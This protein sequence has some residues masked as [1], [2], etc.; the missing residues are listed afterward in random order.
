MIISEHREVLE[1][2]G[3]DLQASPRLRRWI[4]ECASRARP[5][6]VVTDEDYWSLIDIIDWLDDQDIDADVISTNRR[7]GVLAFHNPG[8]AEQFQSCFRGH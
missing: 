2:V 1:V 6:L 3:H 5:L 8:D 4:D 7:H